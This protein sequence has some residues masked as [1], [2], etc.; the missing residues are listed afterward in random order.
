MCSDFHA[1]WNWIS[2]WSSYRI[3]RG[4][5]SWWCL[6]AI[7]VVDGQAAWPTYRPIY[8]GRR[9][10]SFD[11][12]AVP[13]RN[14]LRHGRWP[15]HARGVLGAAA[16]P[17]C[18]GCIVHFWYLLESALSGWFACIFLSPAPLSLQRTEIR[19]FWGPKLDTCL[20]WYLWTVHTAR[21]VFCM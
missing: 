19:G 4:L 17:L 1:D 5:V 7:A 14:L 16:C 11:V 8:Y 15:W 20:Y 9:Y 6:G 2:F 3:C 13:E 12:Q 10:D 18:V 21:C